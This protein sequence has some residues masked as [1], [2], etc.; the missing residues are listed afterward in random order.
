MKELGEPFHEFVLAEL[1][2]VNVTMLGSG[3]PP[4][5]WSK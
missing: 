2:I 5:S 1:G 3:I 4:S